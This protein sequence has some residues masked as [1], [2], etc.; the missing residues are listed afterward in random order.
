MTFKDIQNDVLKESLF[1]L[2]RRR[3]KEYFEDSYNSLAQKTFFL[4]KDLSGKDLK[5]FYKEWFKQIVNDKG[6]TIKIYVNKKHR[7]I[8][9][10]GKF[11]NKV[12][13]ELINE[14]FLVLKR[15]G[16]RARINEHTGKKPYRCNDTWFRWRF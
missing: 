15:D 7:A 9:T 6:E 11:K 13:L 4:S 3:Q 10:N 1:E 14:G 8:Y 5:N 12:I 2:M 16:G